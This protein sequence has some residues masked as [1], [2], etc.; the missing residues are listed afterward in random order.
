MRDSELVGPLAINLT[1]IDQLSGCTGAIVHL[2][3]LVGALALLGALGV[4]VFP[5]AGVAVAALAT[6]FPGNAI[7]G[8]F[9][10]TLVIYEVMEI[11][12]ECAN[13]P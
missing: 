6:Q 9:I 12:H 7:V 4:A 11:Q 5:Q 1:S 2:L 8:A 3:E 13:Q 10:A